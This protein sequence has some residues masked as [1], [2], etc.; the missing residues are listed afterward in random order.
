MIQTIRNIVIVLLSILMTANASAADLDNTLYLELK[1]GRVT[2]EMLPEIAPNH[3]KR[4]K[5]LA[6]QKFY[7]GI[8]FHRVIDG[9][10]AQ[11]GDPT[12]T[13]MSGSGQNIDAEF[14]NENHVRGTVSMARKG[15]D[16]NSADS[17]FF[18]V[19]DDATFLDGQYTVWGRVTDGMEHVDNIKKGSSSNNGSVTSPD[20]IISLRVA[21]G[22]K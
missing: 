1:D 17:Q 15:N 8:V 2:I 20:K 10:M 12:G 18:I 21:S 3:V 7:D 16:V 4:I 9:F 5:E 19:F 14:S 11:A 13:G 22:A 6:N